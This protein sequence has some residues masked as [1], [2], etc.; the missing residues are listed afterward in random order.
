M[1]LRPRVIAEIR[2]LNG[3]GLNDANIARAIGC[4]RSSVVKYRVR[5]KLP[6][7]TIYTPQ[8][9]V[10]RRASMRATFAKL[11]RPHGNYAALTNKCRAAGLGWPGVPLMVACLLRALRDGPLETPQLADRMTL[12]RT[13]NGWRP[14]VVTLGRIRKALSA[15]TKLGLVDR[16]RKGHGPGR[17]RSGVARPGLY[18]LSASAEELQLRRP[19]G[20]PTAIVDRHDL[21]LSKVDKKPMDDAG[22][23]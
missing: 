2:R 18:T 15:G 17:W 7:R 5:M 19:R 12:L 3:E 6:A 4:G 8:S 23:A 13:L 11:G 21:V 16:L 10:L 14:N 22:A 20:T 9:E 1:T